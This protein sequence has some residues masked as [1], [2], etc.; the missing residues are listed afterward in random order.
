MKHFPQLKDQTL[1]HG[2]SAL[3]YL[4]VALAGLLTFSFLWTHWLY[5]IFDTGGFAP[6][7]FCLLWNPPLVSLYVT[8]DAVI[9][10]S[11]MFISAVLIYFVV[12]NRQTIPFQRIFIAFG[13]FIF[14]CG[15][16]HF[17]DIWTLWYA[18][19]W[20][21]GVVKLMTAVASAFTALALPPLIPKAHKLINDAK[22]SEGR[23]LQLEHAHQELGILF[24]KMKEVDRV[25]TQFFANISH[26]LRTPLTLIL[27]SIRNLSKHLQFPDLL[28]AERNALTLLKNVN[29]L[30]EI[31]KLDA[32]KMEMTYSYVNIAHLLQV[33][34]S[35][36]DRLA[37]D[38]QLTVSLH[39]PDLLMAEVDEEKL[40]H[41][42]LNLLS[43]AFKFV[44]V[45]GRID[46]FIQLLQEDNRVTIT[47]Q[48]DGP[49]IPPELRERIFEPFEHD[50]ENVYWN[51]GG[52]GLGLSIVQQYVKLHKGTITVD[53]SPGGGACFTISLP[54]NAPFDAVVHTEA[55][56]PDEMLY[57]MYTTFPPSQDVLDILS[58]EV[59]TSQPLI[60]VVED[61]KDMAY[62]LERILSHL[63]RVSAVFTGE[64][65][66]A[67]I[68]E[69]R[70]DLV[71]CDVMMPGI[72]GEKFVTKV[73]MHSQ[74]A[75][76][77][78]IMLSARSENALRVQLLRE[79]A[80]DYLIKPFFSEE[81]LV[82]VENLIAVKK[83]RSILQQELV[84][85]E[86]N[87]LA[88]VQELAQHKHELQ[89]TLQELRRMNT[90]QANFVA[91]VSHEFRTTLTS[92]QGFSELLS[93]EEFSS[94]EVK[95]FAI[96]MH[97]DARRLL[98]MIDDILDLERLK[99]THQTLQLESVDFNQLLTDVAARVH[100]FSS[101]SSVRLQLDPALPLFQADKDRMIQVMMNLAINAVKYSPDG[102]EIVF[103]S[104]KE[105]NFLHVM[106][107]DHGVG[108][109]EDALEHVF[110]Q[111]SRVH[112]EESRY[113][114]GTGLGLSIVREIIVLHHGH[115]WVESTQ[116]QGSTF[117]FTL[118]LY[119]LL[120]PYE[121][122]SQH[123]Q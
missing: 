85:K 20:L 74:L 18:N 73:R 118:P 98:R 65:G 49:G 59:A 15:A 44:P 25:K 35:H 40:Q 26:E 27:G 102:G 13:T 108:I 82:R 46:C 97:T 91:I 4:S 50:H 72:G 23:R 42:C 105:G 95:E 67:Q 117:H 3:T 69:I 64:D 86:Q 17:M 58:P 77:P 51:T 94:Q 48:D 75:D 10:L 121:E 1:A 22:V 39:A 122:A 34:L 110:E 21:A 16:T 56:T 116:G 107:E 87:V 114:K 113:I 8:S 79:G 5:H 101:H 81:L 80:Q 103:T 2:L 78:I 63:Y 57:Q 120:T 60:L 90:L 47:I 89:D 7:G 88:L 19:Y 76:I 11:Y 84:S 68:L 99:A 109:P 53:D 12:A 106:V 30:L 96:D 32:G 112:A 37:Q 45:G 36:F 100:S 38:H 55:P 62:F 9:G 83:V 70:P 6:H 104:T 41:I 66:L 52:V 29:E 54:L 93:S 92:I 61:N 14:S 31:A 28:V 123:V 119:S 111:Y 115:I 33:S 24:Q 71:I 43:N